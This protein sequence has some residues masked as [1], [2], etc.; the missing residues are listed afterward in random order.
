MNVRKA[1]RTFLF[2]WVPYPGPQLCQKT[3]ALLE[4]TPGLGTPG[5]TP[6]THPLTL[7]SAC[8]VI[9]IRTLSL[10]LYIPQPKTLA[11][12]PYSARGQAG[13]WPQRPDRPPKPQQR[14]STGHED[15]MVTRIASPSARRPERK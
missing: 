12:A 2:P 1:D 14:H 5:K 3:S 7:L 6:P 13:T 8:L 9:L 15:L 10:W 4:T 11:E